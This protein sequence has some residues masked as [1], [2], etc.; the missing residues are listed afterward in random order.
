MDKITFELDRIRTLRISFCLPIQSE[1]DTKYKYR[2]LQ[3]T[4]WEGKD[5]LKVTPKPYVLL[6]LVTKEQKR[7][8]YGNSILLTKPY[9]FSLLHRLQKFIRSYQIPEMFRYSERG[10]LQVHNGLSEQHK[11]ELLALNRVL[12]MKQCVVK[13]EENQTIEYEGCCLFINHPDTYTLL[14]YEELIYFYETLKQINFH[15]LSM[16]AILLNMK[17]DEIPYVE[18]SQE[19]TKESPAETIVQSGP[20]YESG[21]IPNL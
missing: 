7:D 1:A 2:L 12:K 21:T 10:E 4:S 9:F 13:D 16:Q 8:K 17:G 6:E 20:R 14:T 3:K 15:I 5:Y 11:L 19:S 18:W